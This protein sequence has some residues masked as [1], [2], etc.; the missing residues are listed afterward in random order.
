MKSIIDF[1]RPSLVQLAFEGQCHEIRAEK[2][3]HIFT[4]AHTSINASSVK[5]PQ[6]V[7]LLHTDNVFVEE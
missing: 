1:T 6:P 5:L 3:L 7:G 4:Q 2:P